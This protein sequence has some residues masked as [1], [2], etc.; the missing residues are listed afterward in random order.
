[1][2]AVAASTTGTGFG[3]STTAAQEN[4]AVN[5]N[6]ISTNIVAPV[7][8]MAVNKNLNSLDNSPK[9]FNLPVQNVSREPH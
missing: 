5:K 7:A 1:M 9:S 8:N 6:S 4:T 2:H 3:P